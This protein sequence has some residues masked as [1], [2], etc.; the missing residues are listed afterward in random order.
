MRTACL[1]VLLLLLTFSPAQADER[2]SGWPWAYDPGESTESIMGLKVTLYV[3]RRLTPTSGSSLLVVLHGARARGDRLATFFRSWPMQNYVVCAPQ[4]SGST[5]NS[6]DL[7]R[8]RRIVKMLQAGLPINRDRLHVAGFSNGASNLA[9]IAFDDDMKALSGTWVGGGYGGKKVPTWARDRF[10]ALFMAGAD[11]FALNRVRASPRRLHG[12][13]RSLELI[14]EPGIGHTWPSK[15][16]PYHLWWMGVQE[17]R[18]RPG[19]DLNFA[20]G[21]DLGKALAAVRGGRA[22]GAMLYLYDSRTDVG[23]VNARNLQNIIFTRGDI[24]DLGARLLPVKVDRVGN[25]ATLA[26]LGVPAMAT[27]AVVVF[28]AGGRSTHMQSGAIDPSKLVAAL[29]QVAG[30]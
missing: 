20:W 17:G 18:Y 14:I 9:E 13:V 28:G 10:G 6:D 22:R 8:V 7:N 21:N 27:P 1:G 4:A 16:V 19:Y 30:P 3:P 11:D 23:S 15:R 24:R 29:R 5:W 26:A 2:P 12:K 25:T